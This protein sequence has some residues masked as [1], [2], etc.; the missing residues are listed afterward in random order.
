MRVRNALPRQLTLSVRTIPIR[1]ACHSA[2]HPCLAHRP[3]PVAVSMCL[4]A[5]LMPF[6]STARVSVSHLPPGIRALPRFGFS[7]SFRPSFS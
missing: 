5:I 7:Y 2:G 4:A 1:S 6:S 3:C